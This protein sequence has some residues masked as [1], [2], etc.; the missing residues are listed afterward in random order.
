MR[1]GATSYDKR[2]GPGGNGA[3]DRD[4]DRGERGNGDAAESPGAV[5]RRRRAEEREM[6]KKYGMG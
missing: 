5:T 1:V 6:R 3:R 4:R 2:A